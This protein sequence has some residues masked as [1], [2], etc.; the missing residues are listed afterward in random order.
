MA[1]LSG[2]VRTVWRRTLSLS[3]PLA[4]QQTFNTLMR[5]VDIIV[6]GLFS[7][8]AVAAVGLADLYAQLPLRLGLGLG[9]GAI[10]L[11]SQDT[12]RGAVSTRDRSITQAFV[13]GFLVGLPL[14][15]VGLTLSGPLIALLGAEPAVVE[16]GGQYL[17]LVFAAAPMRIVGLVGARS[18][19]G[20][21]DTRTPMVVNGGANVINIAATVGL[22]LGLGPFPNL[23][24]VGVGLATAVSRTVEAIA[25]TVA[26]ASPRTT[27]SFARPRSLTVT[28]QLVAVSLP[29]I[30][31]GLSTSL[32]NFP[33]NAL[34]LTFGTDVTAA[35]HISRRAYQ[36]F[37]GPLYRSYS[38]A[39]SIVVGQLLGED[40]PDEARF[41]GLA[42]T[43]LSVLT[44]GV[45]GVVLVAGARPIAGLFTGDP[46]TLEHATAFT[47][48]FGISMPFFGLFFPLSGSLRG[49]GDTRTPFYARLTGTTLFLLGFSYLA[50]VTLGYGLLGVYAG[51]VL[52]Y[53][54]WALVVGLGFLWGDWAAGAAAMMAERATDAK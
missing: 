51:I 3:W 30:A 37:S 50:G 49:A 38:V 26:V 43:A 11:S 33:F 7:P 12:G 25:I 18:L 15:L 42:I 31:E 21:G 44:L 19:Q 29:N 17:A 2:R 46:A 39:A 36:Q 9:T 40:D 22:G 47:R 4:V 13:I 32:A 54:W 8:A 28:R 6:T 27:P 16:M 5:T 20:T 45:A 41:A 48:A 35:Y 34:L 1:E 53:A 10:A 14:L 52:S 24:I 23:G